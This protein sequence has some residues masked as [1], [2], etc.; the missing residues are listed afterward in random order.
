MFIGS[1]KYSK[2]K[3]P[4]IS[5][6]NKYLTNTLENK[7]QS[8]NINNSFVLSSNNILKS[9]KPFNNPNKKLLLEKLD[10][11]NFNKTHRANQKSFYKSSTINYDNTED[12]LMAQK[13]SSSIMSERRFYNSRIY[14]PKKKNCRCKTNIYDNNTKEKTNSTFDN[15]FLEATPLE[16]Y[17]RKMEVLAKIIKIQSVW[18]GY[19]V[20]KRIKL[21]KFFRLMGNIWDKNDIYYMKLFFMKLASLKFIGDKISYKKYPEKNIIKKCIKF[22]IIKSNRNKKPKTDRKAKEISIKEKTFSKNIKV[23][24]SKNWWMK[25]PLILEKYIKTKTLNLYCPLFLE[26]LKIKAR[27][28][29]KEKRNNL[30]CK[31]INLNDVK[32]L[33]KFMNVYKEKTSANKQKQKIYYSLI[34]SKSRINKKPKIF[35][36]KSFYKKNVLEEIIKKYKYTS[37]IQKYYLLWKKKSKDNNKNKRKRVIKIKT[38]KKNFENKNDLNILK[39]DTFNNVSEISNEVSI[40]SSNTLNSI[41]SSNIMKMCLTSTNK[42]MRIKRIAVDPNY[43]KY[44]GNNNNYTNI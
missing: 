11:S 3:K 24:K 5:D 4:T 35:D 9:I 16:L 32:N 28:N 39:E 34:K 22:H 15:D 43:Y 37:V 14:Y 25:L 23:I 29:L 19:Y 33:K 17:N 41:Q 44:I 27:E 18:R 26:C 40:Y 13:L 42:K 10:T 38:V 30:L 7:P 12:L 8:Y 31:L 1:K 21:Y 6:F 36:F 20:W 2:K